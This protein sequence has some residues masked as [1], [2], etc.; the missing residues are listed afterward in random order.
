MKIHQR[1]ILDI[2]V[3]TSLMIVFGAI[4]NKN[5]FIAPSIYLMLLGVILF[6]GTILSLPFSPIQYSGCSIILA[7]CLLIA[8]VGTEIIIPSPELPSY[9]QAEMGN[10]PEA[11]WQ[12]QLFYE[13]YGMR[14]SKIFHYKGTTAESDIAL[15]LIINKW[16]QE[17][18]NSPIIKHYKSLTYIPKDYAK[19]H[20]YSTEY[21][22][23]Y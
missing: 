18:P 14:T 7:I 5:P 17:H 4:F 22:Q 11:E 2:A 16:N 23:R 12:F 10:T 3:I 9:S 8:S 1:L 20:G 13:K 21:S 19:S 6:I 15:Q